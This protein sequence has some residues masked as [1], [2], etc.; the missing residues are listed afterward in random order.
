MKKNLTALVLALFGYTFSFAQPNLLSPSNAEFS[1]VVEIIVRDYPDKFINLQ[2]DLISHEIN[3]DVYASS[4]KIPGSTDCII[5]HYK[6]TYN[7]SAN[8]QATMYEGEDAQQA[9]KIYRNTCKILQRLKVSL[10]GYN[11]VGFSGNMV[12]VSSDIGFAESIYQLQ[13]KDV[14][15]DDFYAE[16]E[17][18]NAGPFTWVVHLNFYNKKKDE[19]KY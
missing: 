12:D 19:E 5:H 9:K 2:K 4:V 3:Y 1:K 18:V 6:A 13:V 14:L 16:V 10:I 17:L 8:W 7:A 11:A 15:Y